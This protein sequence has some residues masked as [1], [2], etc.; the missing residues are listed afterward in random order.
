MSESPRRGLA[1]LLASLVPEPAKDRLRRTRLYRHWLYV[2]PKS[3][4]ANLDKERGILFIHNPKCG[5]TSIKEALGLALDE[6][7]T[8]H[9]Y[10]WEMV[11][12]EEWE[13]V[14]SI[15]CVRHP[16]DRLYSSYRYHT[17]PNYNG[18][19]ARKFKDIHR[20]T[21]PRYF[22]RLKDEPHG[23]GPQV[24]YL[25]HRYSA[26][27]VDRVLRLEELNRE[28]PY[29]LGHLGLEDRAVGHLNAT[30]S[31]ERIPSLPPGFLEALCHYYREDFRHLRYP[32]PQ[33]R[34]WGT[35][36]PQTLGV[37]E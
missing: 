26:K 9:R 34:K 13:R 24:N 16:F 1:G 27:P 18:H 36:R 17:D 14:Y 10:P 37:G 25:S 11:S 20:L 2:P 8:D 32:L 5:G 21:L 33:K 29:L 6:E 12:A 30:R 35:T 28:L 4:S 22:E 23:I 15:V 7:K 3:D 31:L 19:Y